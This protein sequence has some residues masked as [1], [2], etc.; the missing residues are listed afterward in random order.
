MRKF[1]PHWFFVPQHVFDESNYS[2]TESPTG[3]NR[4][5]T[6]EEFQDGPF[7]KL[8]YHIFGLKCLD[9]DI[10]SVI[11]TSKNPLIIEYT[12]P[13]KLKFV[14][15]LVDQKTGY[16]EANTTIVQTDSAV[17]EEL[18]EYKYCLIA[19]IPKKGKTYLLRLYGVASDD[20]ESEEEENKYNLL[21]QY[22]VTRDGN[23][24]SNLPK[25]Y[26]SLDH[27]IKLMSHNSQFIRFATNPLVIEF[28]IPSSVGVVFSLTD[29]DETK[30]RNILEQRN[31]ENREIVTVFAALP[32]QNETYLLHIFINSNGKLK[33]VNKFHLVRVQS[34][35]NDRIQFCEIY[36]TKFE[37]LIY[38]PIEYYL[39][40][41][42]S[43]EFKYFIKD[44]LDVALVDADDEWYILERSDLDPNIWSLDRSFNS[45][46][47][48]T[49]FAK[50]NETDSYTG[51]CY[52]KV[53]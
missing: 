16:E 20:N 51:I 43:Y 14:S 45:V 35:E 12:S 3:E 26:I 44:A 36:K 30:E 33:Y 10:Q 53:N 22:L 40:S 49:V 50:F 47:K 17:D 8:E 11:N 28:E 31:P 41:D 5:D 52:Y 13:E 2:M 34:N 46:G 37:N 21:S 4:Q 48:L 23:K 42:K 24:Y 6:L 32:K 25:Y 27:E 1:K 19:D 39:K 18:E 29:R 38:S 15:D 9:N 7:N